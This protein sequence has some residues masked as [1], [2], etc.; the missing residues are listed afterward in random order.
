MNWKEPYDINLN[1]QFNW[2]FNYN[3]NYTSDGDFRE[4]RLKREDPP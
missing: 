2:P 3:G 4:V 1:H